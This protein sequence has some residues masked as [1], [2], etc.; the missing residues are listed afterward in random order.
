M[1]VFSLYN[2]SCGVKIAQLEHFE[3]IKLVYFLSSE[4]NNL[5]I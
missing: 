5:D 2:Y 4:G 3:N 1:F